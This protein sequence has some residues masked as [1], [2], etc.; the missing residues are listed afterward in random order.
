M[1]K[2][3]VRQHDGAG[4]DVLL[5][6]GALLRARDLPPKSD[7]WISNS[8]TYVLEM[9]P[10]IHVI[11]RNMN[12]RTGSDAPRAGV[13]TIPPSAGVSSVQKFALFPIPLCRHAAQRDARLKR[14]GSGDGP[15][16]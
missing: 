7:R 2:I 6:I 4:S 8:S 12:F 15:A 14:G 13:R 16:M 9:C 11:F 3:L 1:G 10:E 5:E